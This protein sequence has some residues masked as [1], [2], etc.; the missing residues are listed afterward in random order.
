MDQTEQDHLIN[1]IHV[2]IYDQPVE[3]MDEN[4][5]FVFTLDLIM[6][7]VEDLL[8]NFHASYLMSCG[9]YQYEAN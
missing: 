4:V 3:F 2:L 7:L 5:Q 6:L 9:E 8:L 1:F